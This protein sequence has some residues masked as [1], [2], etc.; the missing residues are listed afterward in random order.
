[1]K[2]TLKVFI[3][4][5]LCLSFY[6]S[7]FAQNKTEV[8]SVVSATYFN[9]LYRNIPNKIQIA[10]PS[11]SCA[12]VYVTVSN[13]TIVGDNCL[14]NVFPGEG[15]SL[16]FY[17]QAISEKD[18]TLIDEWH[19][20]VKK[21]PKPK[22]SFVMKTASD[23]LVK[24]NRLIHTV[25]I[26]SKMDNF[27]IEISSKVTSFEIEI[28]APNEEKVYLKS[29]SNKVTPEMKELFLSLKNNTRIRVFNIKAKS[30][31]GDIFDLDEINLKLVK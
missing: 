18:T 19:Y 23:S 16:T 4:V 3:S 13:G 30:S 20:R 7:S 29:S 6:I 10:V 26:V 28:K 1:M 14:Y 2:T 8:K 22:A 27:D 24:W 11:H 15:N 21:I 5:L 25:G 31:G 9:V 12:E 17:I